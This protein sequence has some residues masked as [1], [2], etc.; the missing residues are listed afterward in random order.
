MFVW[1]DTIWKQGASGDHF[2]PGLG[3]DSAGIIAGTRLATGDGWR[4]IE[5]IEIGDMVLTFDNGLQPV[6]DIASTCCET[7]CLHQDAWPLIA[8]VGALGNRENMKMLPG[9][10]VMIESDIAEEMFGDPFAVLPARA[11]NGLF[12][13]ERCKPEPEL[14]TFEVTFAEDEV[15]F[16]NFGALVHCAAKQ[17]LIDMCM[18]GVG[19]VLPLTQ[20]RKLAELLE[21]ETQGNLRAA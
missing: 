15:V 2:T 17:N 20:A 16:A 12:G 19:K 8:P 18:Q 11:L 4:P 6:E 7:G 21:L 9:Q 3:P 1:K 10:A 5:Q 14:K 13:I